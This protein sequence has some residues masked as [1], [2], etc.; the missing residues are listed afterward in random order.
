MSLTT[1]TCSLRVDGFP[2][3]P[4]YNLLVARHAKLLFL[5]LCMTF[6]LKRRDERDAPYD[7]STE[8][9]GMEMAAQREPCFLEG[10]DRLAV[11]VHHSLP[12]SHCAAS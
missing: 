3:V 4:I 7:S 11:I 9:H 8:Q 10:E 12:N 5:A 6:P 1:S 2:P